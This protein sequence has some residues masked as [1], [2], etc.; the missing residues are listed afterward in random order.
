MYC[1]GRRHRVYYIS[2]DSCFVGGLYGSCDSIGGVRRINLNNVGQPVR[3]IVTGRVHP[4]RAD[5]RINSPP[6]Q[7]ADGGEILVHCE[8]SQLTVI[9][10]DP[11]VDGY[12]AAFILAQHVAQAVVSAL[13][14]ALA[15]G[16]VVELVQLIEDSG[17]VHVFG[18]RAPDLIYE[19]YEPMFAAAVKLVRGDIAFRMALADYANALRDSFVCA[20]LCFRAIEAVKSAFGPGSDADQWARMHAALGTSRVAID[21]AVKAFA[22]PVRHG[23][24]ANF[25]VTTTLQRVAMLK[26]TRDV[27]ERY[28][29]CRQPAA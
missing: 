19:P 20:S 16:Y 25:P 18:V 17:A 3:Y 1:R 24:W 7:P 28:V 26:V 12:I 4:E 11:P 23:D 29:R 6:W 5:V 9:L 8:A 14:F 22:D 15:T 27:L 13:G 10:T 21:T 2:P